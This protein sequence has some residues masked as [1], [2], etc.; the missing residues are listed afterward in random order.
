MR[1]DGI[2]VCA[3]SVLALYTTKLCNTITQ[4]LVVNVW[5][6][7]NPPCEEIAAR[8]AASRLG[9]VHLPGALVRTASVPKA[10]RAAGNDRPTAATHQSSI[11]YR[12]PQL[13][14][15]AVVVMLD[16]VITTG[17]MAAGCRGV[18]T[19]ATRCTDVKGV[20]L[21]RTSDDTA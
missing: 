8:L 19:S 7:G 15:N 1:A 16:D 2:G 21:A 20:Y 17:A 3:D 14:V 12:G 11:E 18:I 4:S 10:A 6:R 5:G 9:T 13:P